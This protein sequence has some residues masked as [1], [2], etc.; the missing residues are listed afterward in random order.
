MTTNP[1]AA[2]LMTTQPDVL[3][4][5]S[6]VAVIAVFAYAIKVTAGTARHARPGAARRPDD[7]A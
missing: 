2:S 5:A 1:E 6:G 4:A 3:I 7:H